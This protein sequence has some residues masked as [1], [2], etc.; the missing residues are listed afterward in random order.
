MKHFVTV[1][2]LAMAAVA[3][4]PQE[5]HAQFLKKLGKAVE[6]VGKEVLS[7][8][9]D[10]T[11]ASSQGAAQS[12]TGT[13]TPQ[14]P[15]KR[16]GKLPAK[17]TAAGEKAAKGKL[18]ILKAKD[19]AQATTT[20]TTAAE[21]ATTDGTTGATTIAPTAAPTTT[22]TTTGAFDGVKIVT[23]H[24]DFK[25]TVNRCVANDKTVLLELTVINATENDEEIYAP[26]GYRDV[27][28]YDDLGNIYEGGGIKVKLANREYTNYGDGIKFLANLP[29]KLSYMINDVSLKAT[30][31]ALADLLISV[32][33]LNVSGDKVKLR[34]IPIQR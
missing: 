8:V 21:P 12:T 15:L 7:T 26:A 19:A 16:L 24:P 14:T 17:S 32:K 33:G 27:K 1:F 2:L 6:T 23:G 31:I 10:S 20:A 29:V 3:T 9:Q 22:P 4:A 11:S 25:I 34:N 5:G 13:A 30:S 18:S 28:F